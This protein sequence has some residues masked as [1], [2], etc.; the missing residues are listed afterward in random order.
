MTIE[1]KA[2]AYDYAI[3]RAEKLY[4]QGT[5]TECLNYVFPELAESEDERIRKEIIDFLE[6][7]HPQ[8]VGNREY[9]KWIAWLEKQDKQKYFDT[10]TIKKKAHQIAWE[11]S[12][13]YDPNACK[14]EWCEMAAIDMASW[15]EKQDDKD[16]LIKEL[17]A[18]QKGLD[19]PYVPGWR[20][21]RPDNKPKIKHSI[22]MLTTH[23]V[24]EGEWLGEEWCQYR[25]S[26]KVKDKEV[27]YWLHLSDLETLEKE[28]VKQDFSWLEKQGEQKPILEV[29][30]FKV[31]DAVRLKDGDGRKHIIKSF[32]EVEGIH[33]HNFYQVEFED[34]SARDGIYPGEEYLNG[35][36]T[37]MEKFEKE[38]KPVDEAEPKFK[39]KKGN[40]YVCI[41]NLDD[42]YGTTAFHKGEIYYSTKDE[43][44]MP[45]NSNIP[46]EIKYYVEDYFRLWT[47]QDAKDGDILCCN[48]GDDKTIYLFK[49]QRGSTD[50]AN[51]H[52]Q[53]VNRNYELRL[54]VDKAADFNLHTKPATKEQRDLLFNKM[55]EAGY[56][57]D[58]EKKELKS[59]EQK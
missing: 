6:L 33:G 54:M 28:N 52:F 29:F 59:I 48:N 31:G 27:L 47:I 26:C 38:Q 36:Y 7:P 32:E 20:E 3:K 42:N 4:E 21:N 40:W 37:Q 23:G 39:I 43:T 10:D 11:I 18:K 2:K 44:L 49:E 57:W 22:L 16:I 35:Y 34:N 15:L 30:G 45:D 55:K 50:I 25:W 51:A 46:Y 8:F 24:A 41:K 58:A 13:H 53:I 1:E 9:E 19:Y 14:Q 5:I 17:I 12:K 56:E